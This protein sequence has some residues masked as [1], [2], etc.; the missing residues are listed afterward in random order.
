M[1]NADYKTVGNRAFFSLPLTAPDL[2]SPCKLYV[3][4]I[5]VCKLNRSTIK[6]SK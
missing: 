5:I 6:R 3:Q 2:G 4:Y 1:S